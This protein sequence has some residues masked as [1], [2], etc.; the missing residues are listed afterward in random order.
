MASAASSDPTDKEAKD[1]RNDEELAAA[2]AEERKR[3]ETRDAEIAASWSKRVVKE[4]EGAQAYRGASASVHVTGRAIVDADVQGRAKE[5]GFVSGS[6]F[7]DSRARNCPI[8]LLLG[9]GTLVPGLDRALLEMRVGE[10]AEVTVGPEGGYGRAGSVE[11]PCVPGSATLTYDVEM[12]DLESEG[13][14][15]D[16][17]FESK[18]RYATER[19]ERGNTLIGGGHILMADA[20]YEQALR[21]LVFMPHPEPHEQPI[22]GQSL[23]AGARHLV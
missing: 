21:Y 11:L 14:L 10:R 20:E 15:W 9:R 6:I 13:E 4:G 16:L 12:L 8:K 5:R 18:M 22:I 7:D 3:Q 19:R 1:K 17:S 23:A 2:Q